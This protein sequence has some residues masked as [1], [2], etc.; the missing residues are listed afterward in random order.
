MELNVELISDFVYSASGTSIPVRVTL[1]SE[2]PILIDSN[3]S[4]NRLELYNLELDYFSFGINRNITSKRTNAIELSSN[5]PYS[6]VVDLMDEENF[7]EEDEVL[8][9]NYIVKA[10]VTVYAYSELGNIE[11]NVVELEKEVT[12][13]IVE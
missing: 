8:S 12:V 3:V 13:N 11:A 2:Q 1:T 7:D 4:I 10:T 5:K 9:G 6:T